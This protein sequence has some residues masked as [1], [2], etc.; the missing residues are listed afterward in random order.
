MRILTYVK[1]AVAS[2][3]L[4]SAAAV[5]A[6]SRPTP[7]YDTTTPLDTNQPFAIT[8]TVPTASDPRAQYVVVAK[9]SAVFRCL[10]CGTEPIIEVVAWNDTTTSLVQTSSDAT[11]SVSG[12]LAA[13]AITGLDSGRV[14][15]AGVDTTGVLSI[16]TWTVGASGVALQNSYSTAA[17][18]VSPEVAIATLSSTEVVTAYAL[19]NGTLAVEAWTIS[20]EGLPTPVSTVGYQNGNAT[21][22]EVLPAEYGVFAAQVSIATVNPTQV[23]TAIGD[24]SESMWVTSWGINSGVQAQ[25]L[26]QIPNTVSTMA[27]SVAVGAG[28]TSVFVPG[29][30]IRPPHYET[31]QTAFTPFINS[32]SAELN[33]LYW[34]ISAS[35]QLTQQPALTPTCCYYG[36]VAATTLPTDVPITSYDFA[37]GGVQTDE[38]YHGYFANDP[39]ATALSPGQN[40]PPVVYGINFVLNGLVGSAAE[41]NSPSS[42][43]E[44]YSAYF[45]S[46]SAD[47]Y[48][49]V[50]YIR[51]FSYPLP[52]TGLAFR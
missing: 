48:D 36:G 46:A 28:Q 29:I 16:K 4:A 1:A 45:V 47:Q 10:T 23:V 27:E 43:L 11:A 5:C 32:G 2:L 41:G 39:W 8:T 35:G 9:A 26:Q 3:V 6:Q 21:G 30:G 52:P 38:Y 51:V 50:L 34:T 18:S 19:P 40:N 42:E 24:S 15:T 44:P 49:E 14:V 33:V 17:E 13:V 37:P 31:V 25:Q 20:A 12:G 7:L 22:N